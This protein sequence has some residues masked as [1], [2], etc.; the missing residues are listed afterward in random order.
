MHDPH[1]IHSIVYNEMTLSNAH[2]VFP[3]SFVGDPSRTRV[4]T[5]DLNRGIEGE[6]YPY[7][8]ESPLH[9]NDGRNDR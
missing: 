9:I 1:D 6:G 5:G 2:Y 4:R 8:I 3:N 7:E